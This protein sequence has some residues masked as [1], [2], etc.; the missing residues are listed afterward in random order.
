M[1]FPVGLLVAAAVAEFLLIVTKRPVFGVCARYCVWFGAIGAVA[2]ATLGWFFAVTQ[3]PSWLLATHRWLGT[4]TAVWSILL[5]VL[6][7]LR[8]RW[9]RIGIC[10]AFR[11][12]LVIG[13]CLVATTGFFGGA[14]VYGIDHYAWPGS[15]HHE[16]Q[17]SAPRQERPA[18]TVTVTMTN[19]LHFQPRSVTVQEG[20]TVIWKNSSRLP[21]TVTADPEL[22]QN[23]KDVR[24]PTGAQAFNSGMI[25]PGQT[26]SHTFTVAGDYGY[27]CIPHELMGMLGEVQVKSSTNSSGPLMSAP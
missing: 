14:M 2:A 8:F 24:L 1:N 16:E 6:A 3:P 17:E 10:Y 7:E 13:V 4:S 20:G 22:A 25:D 27:F 18:M 9:N 11:F 12:A 5:L 19:D 15:Q 21:H 26:Y 23:A